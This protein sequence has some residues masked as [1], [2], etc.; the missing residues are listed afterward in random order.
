METFDVPEQ[1]SWKIEQDGKVICSEPRDSDREKKTVFIRYCCIDYEKEYTITCEGSADNGWDQIFEYNNVPYLDFDGYLMVG[2][3]KYCDVFS[4]GEISYTISRTNFFFGIF[5]FDCCNYFTEVL[6]S[7][8][9][10]QCACF[11][12]FVLKKTKISEIL[13]FRTTIFLDSDSI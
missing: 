2:D 7:L 8:L 4:G 1:M 3:N 5:C 12:N 10:L 9:P 6:F 13:P 11:V